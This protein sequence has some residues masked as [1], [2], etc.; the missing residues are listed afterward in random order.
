LKK[1]FDSSGKEVIER[2][3]FIALKWFTGNWF[4]EYNND[5]KPLA[6][7]SVKFIYLKYIL[8]IGFG[9]IIGI[10]YTFLSSQTFTPKPFCY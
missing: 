5:V 3:A 1:G 6:H 8:I 2:F 10:F 7:I 4:R 9:P